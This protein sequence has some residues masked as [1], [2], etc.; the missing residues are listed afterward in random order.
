VLVLAG[1]GSGKTRVITHRVANLLDRGVQPKCIVA[2]SF[3]NKA[4]GEMRDRLQRMV[5]AGIARELHLATFHSLGAQMLREDPRG[6]GLPS[7]KFSIL[8]QGDIF[9]MIRGLL[10]EHGHHGSGE[11]RR[12]DLPGIAQ[13]I[14]LWKNAF[15]ETSA[16]EAQVVDEYDVVT[17]SIYAPFEERLRTMGAVDFD[18][19]VCL[20]ARRLRDDPALR[21]RFRSEFSHVMVDEY[22]DTSDAQFELLRQ[23]VAPPHNLCVVG[24]D[25]QAIYG[26]RGAKVENILQFE[27]QFPG[28]R[29]IKLEQNYR[30]REPILACA[31]SII[32]NNKVR[33]VKA[34]IPTRHGG[35]PV[36][37]VVAGDG[38]QEAAW[39]S[40]QIRQLIHHEGRALRDFAVLY[41][42][43]QQAKPIEEEL[44]Q[45]G[46]PYRV[47]GGQSVYDKK[48]VKDAQAYLK[49]I[50]MPKDELA[51]RRAMQTPPRGIGQVA[52]ERLL[53]HAESHHVTLMEAVLQADRIEDLP[54][55]AL[56]AL[57]RFGEIVT[58]AQR[59]AH[60]RN[61]VAS[62][63]ADVLREVN[64]RDHVRRET[65]SDK[66]TDQR[67]AAVDSLV[68]SIGRFERRAR[69]RNKTPRWSDYFG[70]SIH[71]NSANAQD[72][73]RRDDRITL[74][75][76]HS[77]KG[78]EWDFVFLIGVE[79]GT[80]P[81]RR[82]A[83]PR[84]SDAIAG[85][86]EEERRLFYVGITR[87][88]EQLWITR[89]AARTDRG[90]EIPR[91]PSRFIDELP[92]SGLRQYDIAKEEE[93][94]SEAIGDMAN[95]FLRQIQ[96]S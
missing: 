18:D 1:A 22:Q 63:L 56:P 6:F 10:R 83:S 53:A 35:A 59:Q 28:T 52:I 23:L 87:A 5:G 46:L 2:L 76:L 21:T 26:W 38:T 65:G 67:M 41:R 73:A 12:Y 51:I 85:D 30:S 70:A 84:A 34:L 62:A 96:P 72:E 40:K 7:A 47:L 78:L 92:K 86:V 29:V 80:L 91:M 31:N 57:Q 44:Q 81:H 15:V 95:A 37:L 69:D 50:V 33:H 16:V 48:E 54:A 55:R 90:R 14:S 39:I 77:A 93:L 36:S 13:R 27:R 25:D 49:A 71:D 24:D 89:C 88:R 3:T 32:G 74:A 17:A 45:N 94:S 66:A 61:D 82:V 20:V 9:G 8:D 58:T 19:L 4:A 79:E 60:A 42:S 43:A 64:M 68:E 75:T 11:D